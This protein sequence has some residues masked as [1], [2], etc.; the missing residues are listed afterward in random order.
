[1]NL[2]RLLSIAGISL[3]LT[4]CVAPQ[5]SQSA[6]DASYLREYIDTAAFEPGP[7]GSPLPPQNKAVGEEWPVEVKR[8]I[9][10]LVQLFG[11]HQRATLTTHEIE[12]ALGVRLTRK[13][14]NQSKVDAIYEISGS[15]LLWPERRARDAEYRVGTKKKDGR[16]FHVFEFPIDV[17]RFC[18]NPYHF[19]IYTGT[20][21]TPEMPVHGF[22][23]PDRDWPMAYEWGMFNR[24]SDGR[25][26][27]GKGV[28][29]ALITNDSCI[30]KFIAM[31]NTLEE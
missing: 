4:A 19:A 22:R 15:D 5:V 24:N 9:D 3:L 13:S 26:M 17:V 14:L 27:P 20:E 29:I 10:H 30:F 12:S 31:T 11:K 16:R 6:P 7:L 2:F 1:M 18:V 25:F 8:F 21:Y 23:P 28:R